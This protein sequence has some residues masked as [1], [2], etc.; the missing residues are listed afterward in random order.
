M[1]FHIFKN[2]FLLDFKMESSKDKDGPKFLLI[3][4]LSNSLQ[5]LIKITEINIYLL[6]RLKVI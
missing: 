5:Y 6:Y 3:I 2:K 1:S 4:H